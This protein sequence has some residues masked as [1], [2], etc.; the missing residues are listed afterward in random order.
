MVHGSELAA[1]DD[2]LIETITW[3]SCLTRVRW[4]P[5]TCGHQQT[6]SDGKF[7][8]A[9]REVLVCTTV[10]SNQLEH[11]ENVEVL[12]VLPSASPPQHH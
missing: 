3:S 4:T 9:I 8:Q 2:D 7:S 1:A 12:A 11:E 5:D 10:F 6:N